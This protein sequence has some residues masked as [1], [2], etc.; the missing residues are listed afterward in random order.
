MLLLVA[1]CW[2]GSTATLT[3]VATGFDSITDVRQVPGHEQLVVL[4]KKGTVY[5]TTLGGG[6]PTTWWTVPV[7]DGSEMGLLSVAF[8]PDFATSGLLY[9]HTNPAGG[10][11][12]SQVSRW[13]TDP[14][15]LSAPERL[16]TVLELP[17]PYGNHDGGQ[18]RFGADGMLYVAFG[19]GGSANDPLKAGQDRSTWLGSILRL[20]V[21]DPAV[22]YRVPPDNPFVGQEG[23]KPEIWAWGL[24]NPW[25]FVFLDDGRA[26]I[27]DV[28]QNEVEELTIGGAGANHGWNMWEGD[29]C[30]APPCSK[31]GMTMPDHTYTHAVGQSITGGIVPTSGRFAGRYLFGDFVSGRLWA[32]D[33]STY[34]VEPLGEHAF[35]PSTFALAPDG[36]PLAADFR[37]SLYRVE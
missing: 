3:P 21:S 20:D 5:R 15:T 14:A 1:G 7:R 6:P 9:L 34:A 18:L 25:R 11:R 31:Q 4:G 8:A 30:F 19:D 22:P 37:G 33:L 36:A 26:L 17:Q 10:E 35:H 13:K 29:R 27:A 28:G 23:V 16:G 2:A 24:R 12:R 32:M